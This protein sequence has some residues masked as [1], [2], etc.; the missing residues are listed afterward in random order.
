MRPA[1]TVWDSVL[2]M[3]NDNHKNTSLKRPD[4]EISGADLMLPAISMIL[5]KWLAFSDQYIYLKNQD[6][7]SAYIL[8]LFCVSR[9]IL[10]I[11]HLNVSHNVVFNQHINYSC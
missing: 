7:K 3:N 2:N 6:Y 8:S 5:S 1:G 10:H 4:S 9:K 11:K